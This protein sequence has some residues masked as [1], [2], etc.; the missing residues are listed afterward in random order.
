MRLFLSRP[1]TFVLCSYKE[2]VSSGWSKAVQ[3]SNAIG[4]AR[5][6]E[7]L[8]FSSTLPVAVQAVVNRIY[9][10][11][12][13]HIFDAIGDKKLTEADIDNAEAILSQINRLVQSKSVTHEQLAGLSSEYYAIFGANK[14]VIRDLAGIERE[15][16]LCQV[17]VDVVVVVVVFI[18]CLQ[19]V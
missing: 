17:C 18:S 13:S 19:L 12:K 15:Q 2:K 11:A 14:P 16:Q 3:T 7:A 5:A 8:P 1:L 4:S 9:E 6:Q 10:S